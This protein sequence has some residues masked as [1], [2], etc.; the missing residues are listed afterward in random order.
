MR[1][2]DGPRPA[3]SPGR[4]VAILATA[5][6]V[7]NAALRWVPL[8]LP[9]LAREF[10]T[11]LSRLTAVM[12]AGELLGISAVV[13]GRLVQRQ[14]SRRWLLTGLVAVL[15]ANL[16]A[17]SAASWV[18]FAIG[19]GL[20]VIGQS[21]CNVSAQ[22]WIGR[23][24]DPAHRGRYLGAF[25]SSWALALL[26]GVPLAA[27]TIARSWRGPFLLWATAGFVLV[28][29][30]RRLLPADSGPAPGGD[31]DGA[32]TAPTERFPASGR[33]A[34][35]AAALLMAACVFTV[36]VSGAW[37][38][39]RFGLGPGGLA[40]VAFVLGTAELAASI[41]VARVNDR[42]GSARTLRRGI[43]VLLLGAAIM[44]VGGGLLPL[45]VAGLACFVGGFELAYISTLGI[46]VRHPPAIVARLVGASAASST[47]SRAAAAALAGVLYAHTGSRGVLTVSAVA[48]AATL[49]VLPTVARTE[50]RSSTTTG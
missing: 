26:F 44:A 8:F 20:V 1:A 41:T 29:A 30:V 43:A 15:V 39:D 19:Y 25:E 49:M 50:Q 42:W 11:P 47:V 34:V 14:G 37:L 45:A 21:C 16:T 6:A 13:T 48:A 4:A 9:A 46:V 17:A 24:I 38:E 31:T 5:R 22:A 33:A 23:N 35:A 28:V 36:V 2:P 12:G 10:D 40:A 32:D 18:T 7:P 27:A 3:P